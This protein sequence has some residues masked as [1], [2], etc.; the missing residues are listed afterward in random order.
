MS[1]TVTSR[2]EETITEETSI[3]TARPKH[4]DDYD[5]AKWMERLTA[6]ISRAEEQSQHSNSKVWWMYTAGVLRLAVGQDE[7]GRNNLREALL[8]PDS[9]MAHHFIRLAL[10]EST[11]P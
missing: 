8:L 11:H 2:D 9:R 1:S 4:L 6:A 7:S 10:S 3:N 5:S